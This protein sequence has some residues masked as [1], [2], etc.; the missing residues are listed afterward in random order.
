MLE[1]LRQVF[2]QHEFLDYQGTGLAG[3][4]D[5]PLFHEMRARAVDVFLTIDRSQLGKPEE[6]EAIRAGGCH[7]VGFSAGSGKGVSQVART[8]AM[9]LETVAYISDNAPT[10]PTAYRPKA[11]GRQPNQLFVSVRPLSELP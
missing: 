7:W 1:P 2:A 10:V 5:V 4:K 8:G 6:L 9:L 3:M 11:T